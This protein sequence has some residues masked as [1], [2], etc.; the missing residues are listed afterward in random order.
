M[1]SQHKETRQLQEEQIATQIEKRT[2]LLTSQEKTESEISKDAPLKK[3]RGDLR[4]WAAGG[5]GRVGR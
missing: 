5:A 4:R 1:G 2:A 3:L